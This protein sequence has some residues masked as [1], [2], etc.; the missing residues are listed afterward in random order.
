[1]T[2]RCCKSKKI[3]KY[4]LP[5]TH[6]MVHENIEHI[7]CCKLLRKSLNS[8]LPSLLSVWIFFL[9]CCSFFC[10]FSTSSPFQ[11]C[12]SSPPLPICLKRPSMKDT[13]VPL[14]IKCV[15]LLLGRSDVGVYTP[16]SLWFTEGAV[17]SVCEG[18]G[19]SGKQACSHL[20]SNYH[21]CQSVMKK[22]SNYTNTISQAA[23]MQVE[24]FWTVYLSITGCC[25]YHFL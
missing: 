17:V 15:S 1:M 2:W 18:W 20:Y 7:Y 25:Q 8:S 5:Q 13:H 19:R 23:Y 3:T 16:W 4:S 12:P 24:R 21:Y 11:L 10:I 6:T 14:W 9:S 22:T